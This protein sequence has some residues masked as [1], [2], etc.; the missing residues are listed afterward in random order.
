MIP[1]RTYIFG[2]FPSKITAAVASAIPVLFLGEGEGA[3]LVSELNIGISL[4]FDEFD[5]LSE[6]LI[7]YSENREEAARNFYNNLSEAQLKSFDIAKNN[8]NLINFLR[9]L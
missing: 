5:S 1:L 6:Y 3:K 7:S 9:R 4:K 2:A 8:Q